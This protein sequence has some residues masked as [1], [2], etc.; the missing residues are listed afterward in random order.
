MSS[1][2]SLA[3]IGV[4][5]AAF[6]VALKNYWRKSGT[7]IRGAF[8]IASSRSC[9]HLYV[10]YVLLENL[11]DRAVTIF[12]VYL[13]IGHSYYIQLLD[14]DE[15]SPLILRAFETFKKDFGPIEF[16][17]VNTKRIS[18]NEVLDNP[19]VRKRLVLSTADGRYVVPSRIRRWTPIGEFF[20]NHLAAVFR[21]VMSQ[22][23]DTHLGGNIRYVVEF[24]T[25]EGKE[26]II[27]IHPEDYR[28]K[29]FKSFQLTQDSLQS[30]EALE[31]Y[32]LSK[33]RDGILKCSKV[34]VHDVDAW[35]AD[36]H[37]LYSGETVSAKYYNAF[38][39][40]VIGNFITWRSNRE[41]RRRNRALRKSRPS[42]VAAETPN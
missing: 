16:Y 34:I 39:F 41:L 19:R 8:S 26:E 11:K 24:R 38:Q 20:D 3:A 40:Y 12:G 27:P 33:Q 6:L 1:L 23:K 15:S 14:L 35:R 7:H 5:S 31:Q 30:R 4:S 42:N 36:T 21:P 10:S 25:A 9:D 29:I 18:L 13:Q 22:Y 32:L 2:L 28:L 37:R 17:T